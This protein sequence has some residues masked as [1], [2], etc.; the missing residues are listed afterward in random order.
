MYLQ[1]DRYA[2]FNA[3]S[4]LFA[5]HREPSE[6]GGGYLGGAAGGRLVAVKVV[7]AHLAVDQE[8]RTRFAREVEA[9]RRVSGIFTAPVIDADAD[10]PLPW[11]ATGD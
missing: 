9:V 11:L 10:A 2:C 5:A 8:F 4:R 6:C 7:H 3:V 1:S